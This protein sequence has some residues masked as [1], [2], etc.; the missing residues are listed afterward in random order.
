MPLLQTQGSL[1]AEP[2]KLVPWFNFQGRATGGGGK[3][4]EC[5]ITISIQLKAPGAWPRAQLE[6]H[7]WKQFRQC[8]SCHLRWKV[9]EWGKER[10]CLLSYRPSCSLPLKRRNVNLCPASPPRLPFPPPVSQECKWLF[11]Y[12]KINPVL[13]GRHSGDRASLVCPACFRIALTVSLL[14]VR[15]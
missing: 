6:R 12:A 10:R 1:A 7:I 13:K 14:H 3:R 5:K 15:G 2:G 11:S 4:Q 8:G 9:G